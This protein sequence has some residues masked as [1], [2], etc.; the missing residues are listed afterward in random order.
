MNTD[1]RLFRF[2]VGIDQAFNP[3]V[4]GGSE[5]VT[6]SAQSAYNELILH[7][8]MRKRKAIDWLFR[9]V[10]KQEFHCYKSLLDE[11]DEFENAD[12]IRIMLSEKG[13]NE[14]G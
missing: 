6:I 5:D 3:L 12:L 8:D 2:I 13:L 14:E 10:F 9:T 1:S 7:K 4:Y 11:I